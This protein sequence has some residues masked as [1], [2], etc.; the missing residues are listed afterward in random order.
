MGGS[1]SNRADPEI[2]GLIMIDRAV[3]L[4]SPFCIQMNYEG[5]LDEFFGI[6][7]TYV[8]VPRRIVVPDSEENK[9]QNLKDEL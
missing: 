2:D 1:L 6:E 4:V 5:L 3:D 8:K 7:T 9:D